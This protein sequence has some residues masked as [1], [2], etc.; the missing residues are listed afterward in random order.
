MMVHHIVVADHQFPVDV[1]QP[2]EGNEHLMEP[3]S[4][5]E[6]SVIE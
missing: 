6:F 5:T 2:G 1:P 4:L 3:V